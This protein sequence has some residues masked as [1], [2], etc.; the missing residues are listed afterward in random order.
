M[1]NLHRSPRRSRQVSICPSTGALSTAASDDE[2]DE[3]N[4]GCGE[5]ERLKSGPR[6]QEE[7]REAGA[8]TIKT[9]L[10]WAITIV[11]E[12]YF[13]WV[14]ELEIFYERARNLEI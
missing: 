8:V 6:I 13:S 7:N 10:K 1:D 11:R 2:E 4:D 9:Y 12:R 5:E 3:D 14:I